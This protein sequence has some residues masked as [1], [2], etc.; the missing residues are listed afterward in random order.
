MERSRGDASS[1]AAC[2]SAEVGVCAACARA[3]VTLRRRELLLFLQQV[4]EQD[5]GRQ[6]Y[7]WVQAQRGH[8]APARRM[9]ERRRA[10]TGLQAVEE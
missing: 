4:G 6:R 7:E 1:C 9:T 3:A 2:T 5:R 8:L 10:G